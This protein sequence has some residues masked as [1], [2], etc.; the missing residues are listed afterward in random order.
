MYSPLKSYLEAQG[1]AVYA[2]VGVCD[3]AARKDG[4]L[5]LI[6]MKTRF[7]LALLAQAVTRQQMSDSVYVAVPV[8]AGR[9]VPP[10]WKDACK[11][12]RRLELGLILVRFLRRGTRVEVVFHPGTPVARRSHVKRGAL[13]REI[14]GRYR[15]LN[16]GGSSTR[17][18]RVTAYRQAALRIAVFLE[19]LGPTSP[20]QLRSMDCSPRCQTIL[21]DNHYGWFQRVERGVYSLHRAGRSALQHYP[22]LTTLFREELARYDSSPDTT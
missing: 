2:E 12:L 22:E 8:A 15:E 7:S 20:R 9:E 4:E 14:N 21:A 10:G 6:E 5:V 11:V 3:I 13:L 1:Y 19:A 18:G 17:S 16:T